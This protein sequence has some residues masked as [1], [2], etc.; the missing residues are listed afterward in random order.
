LDDSQDNKVD[1][2]RLGTHDRNEFAAVVRAERRFTYAWAQ[3]NGVVPDKCSSEIERNELIDWVLEQGPSYFGMFWN[4]E[5]ALLEEL[6]MSGVA[7][8]L[9][10]ATNKKASSR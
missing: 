10:T 8:R 3:D 6:Q 7:A 1:D 4:E 9:A 2:V 5:L